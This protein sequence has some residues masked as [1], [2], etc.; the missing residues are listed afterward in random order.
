M[1]T[2][3]ERYRTTTKDVPEE[4][5]R[6]G[7]YMSL[8]FFYSPGPILRAE[9]KRD[10]EHSGPTLAPGEELFI[11]WQKR[12]EKLVNSP[13]A[14]KDFDALVLPRPWLSEEVKREMSASLNYA[15]RSRV[16]FSRPNSLKQAQEGIRRWQAH[17]EK[18]L[19]LIDAKH[20]FI[21]ASKA[22]SAGEVLQP[23]KSSFVLWAIVYVV[24][25][26]LIIL[27][28]IKEF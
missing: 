22:P 16:D 14:K 24:L 18:R 17:W 3:L 2:P 19:V 27:T 12:L 9:M 21:L 23:L 28:L 8:C 1:N 26:G 25:A 5:K 4:E 10:F 13:A 15:V 7:A 6:G 11:L 20:R